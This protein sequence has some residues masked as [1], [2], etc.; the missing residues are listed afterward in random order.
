MRVL[1]VDA[2]GAGQGSVGR[3]LAFASS[4]AS[5]KQQ[6]VVAEKA[7]ADLKITTSI[8]I[9]SG[10]ILVGVKNFGLF[11]RTMTQH[12]LPFD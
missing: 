3:R 7:L 11:K 4:A 2:A 12:R 8:G 5:N 6:A 10:K 9:A 1:A